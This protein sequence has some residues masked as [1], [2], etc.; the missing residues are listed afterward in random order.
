MA[1]KVSD[2]HYD[3][4]E[5]EVDD[6]MDQVFGV[7]MRMTM[8]LTVKMKLEVKAEKTTDM[9]PWN[10]TYSL[11]LVHCKQYYLCVVVTPN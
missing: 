2:S 6:I 11:S 4:L 5:E 1:Q 3:D 10:W 8:M 9:I 7:I